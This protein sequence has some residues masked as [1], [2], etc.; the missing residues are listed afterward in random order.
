MGN[1]LDIA[2]IRNMQMV[3]K[4][5]AGLY[6]DLRKNKWN[7][8][9]QLQPF[10]KDPVAF[11]S[12][13]ARTNALIISEFTAGFFRRTNTRDGASPGYIHIAD[14]AADSS[15]HHISN[16]L[17]TEGYQKVSSLDSVST[18]TQIY[19]RNKTDIHRLPPIESRTI[20]PRAT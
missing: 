8:N 13:Q 10:F 16:Y 20:A 6:A 17:E 12:L 18:R 9:T 11:R 1:Y 4:Q 3:C 5:A 14:S 15:H 7:I 19:Y 2:D